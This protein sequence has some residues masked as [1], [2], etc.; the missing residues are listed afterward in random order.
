M[1]V[2]SEHLRNII[3]K[4][5]DH[6]EHRETPLQGML[7]VLDACEILMQYCRLSLRCAVCAGGLHVVYLEHLRTIIIKG[8]DIP[9]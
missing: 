3:I 1:P 6:P 7:I 5:V 9:A 2:Y 8:V 4:G